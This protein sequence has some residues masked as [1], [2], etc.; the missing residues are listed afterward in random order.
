MGTES[1]LGEMMSEAFAVRILDAYR[2]G[3]VPSVREHDGV[4]LVAPAG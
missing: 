4:R 3:S 1:E 2:H